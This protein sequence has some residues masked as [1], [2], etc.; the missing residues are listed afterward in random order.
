[1]EVRTN[2]NHRETRLVALK[3]FF[4]CFLLLFHFVKRIT[5]YLNR[6]QDKH[7]VSEGHVKL[8]AAASAPTGLS[9]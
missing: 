4:I 8:G 6:V 9:C 2:E 5:S 1:M 7:A 3:L